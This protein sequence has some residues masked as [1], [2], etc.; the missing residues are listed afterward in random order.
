MKKT[1][2]F[3]TGSLLL[4]GALFGNAIAMDNRYLVKLGKELYI[5]ENLSRNQNQSCMTCHHPSGG[6]ADPENRHDPIMFPVSDGSNPTLF[7]GRNA[8]TAAYSGFS[9]VMYFD[10]AEGLYIGGTF[11][12]GRATGWTLGD[13]IAEQ[14][15]GPFLN[16]V[17]MGLS[18]KEEVISIVQN[19]GYVELFVKVFG[20]DWDLDVEEAYNNIGH[21]IAA[22]ERSKRFVKFKSKFDKFWTEQGGDVSSFGVDANGNYIGL[23]A[24]FKSEHLKPKQADGLALFNAVDKGNCAAC[25]LTTNHIEGT[26]EHPPLFTDFTYDNLGVPVNPQIEVLTGAAQPIDYGLG[27]RTAE[28][29]ALTPAINLIAVPEGTPDGGDILVAETE[30]GKFKVPTLRNLRKTAPYGHNG[31]FVTLEEITHFYNTRDIPEE[32]WPAPEVSLNVNRDELGNLGLT[33]QEEAAI[34]AF[35]KTLTD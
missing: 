17:E 25:H 16:P 30:A 28:L 10:E 3:L 9:P 1:L 34:V 32:G 18:S 7:G 23:P 26:T 31:F 24:G 14:A 12:D 4:T 15:L 5:D 13:P 35:M 11:W 21:A 8:P 22:F 20:P 33:P 29:Q 6:F 27:A 19:S 2:V